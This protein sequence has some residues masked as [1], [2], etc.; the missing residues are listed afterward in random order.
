MQTTVY[1]LRMY[2][3]S[4]PTNATCQSRRDVIVNP[5]SRDPG[6]LSDPSGVDLDQNLRFW[7]WSPWTYNVYKARR[8]STST[9]LVI[10]NTVASPGMPVGDIF[11]GQGALPG[12][13]GAPPAGRCLL[14][15]VSAGGGP[16]SIVDAGNPLPGEAWYYA[17]GRKVGHKCNNGLSSSKPA[18]PW[19]TGLRGPWNSW[20][21]G[22]SS[23]PDCVPDCTW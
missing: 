20:T 21:G 8:S 18:L 22:G 12:V 2:C 9:P 11:I 10:H 13:T 19:S 23:G 1:R 5:Y 14:S 7:K 3:S 16:T 17:V 6:N 4:D 15:V